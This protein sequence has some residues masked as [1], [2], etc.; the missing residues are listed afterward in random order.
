M[1]NRQKEIQAFDLAIAKLNE[2]K[3]KALKRIAEEEK[4]KQEKIKQK[5]TPKDK[6]L[7]SKLVKVAEWWRTK[8]PQIEK[9][10]KITVRANLLWTED[11]HPHV[12]GYEYFYNNKPLDFDELIR[13]DLFDKE[14]EEA[15]KQIDKICDAADKLE[16]KYPGTDLV[17]F[18]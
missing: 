10:I 4:G 3:T 11:K 18:H 13:N 12:D 2:E 17:I 7:I 16:K 1:K 14:L 9:T 6:S 8:G 5:I 15:K